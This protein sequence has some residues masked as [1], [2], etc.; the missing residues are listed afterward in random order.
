MYKRQAVAAAARAL[1]EAAGPDAV[2]ALA[3]LDARG[4][5]PDLDAVI[6]TSRC[7]ALTSPDEA[8]R[9]AGVRA[10][11]DDVIARAAATAAGACHAEALDRAAANAQRPSVSKEA[12]ALCALEAILTFGTSARRT[13]TTDVDAALEAR[14]G[15]ES[16]L[17]LIHI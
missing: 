16:D 2:A 7:R 17:S 5:L 9:E 8:T 11:G 13:V 10:C 3:A 4:L 1:A 12:A 15:D 14:L 6:A